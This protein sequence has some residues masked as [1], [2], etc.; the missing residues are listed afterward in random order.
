[1]LN[2]ITNTTAM[3]MTLVIGYKQ[4]RF[5]LKQ[6]H[7]QLTTKLTKIIQKQ[8]MKMEEKMVLVNS[9]GVRM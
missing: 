4:S 3:I 6:K 2:F 5:T 7:G 1:M 9:N 8:P